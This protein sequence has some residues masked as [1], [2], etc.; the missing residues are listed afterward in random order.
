MRSVQVHD[1]EAEAARAGQRVGVNLR[2]VDRRR[3]RA[4]PAGW[5]R[6]R[7]AGAA[8]RVFDAWITLLPRRASAA[9]RR[10]GAPAPRHRRSSWRAWRRSAARELAPGAE[11]AG[12]SC[13]S[14]A[15]PLVEPHDR[16]ILRSL[17]PVA[18]VGGGGRAR[19]RAAALA[20]PRRARRDFSRAL[21]DGDAPRSQPCARGRRA[22][23]GLA[24]AT[25]LDR[26]RR[27]RAR[28]LRWPRAERPASSRRRRLAAEPPGS[29]RRVDRRRRRAALVRAGLLDAHAWRRWRRS[30][31]ARSPS[32]RSGRS[33]RRPSSRPRSRR[34]PA[35]GRWRARPA[36]SSTT[37]RVVRRRGRLTPPPAP[38]GRCRRRRRRWRR[39]LASGSPAAGWRR[40]RWPRW[41]RRLGASQA[42]ARRVCSTVLVRARRAGARREGPLVRRRRRRRSA[43]RAARRGARRAD[44][45]VTLAGFRDLAGTGRRN[46]QALLELFDREG[47][48]RRQGDVRVLRR[49]S[50]Y[51]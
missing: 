23:A 5:W 15:T 37:R 25:C 12:A 10:P 1:R 44:G 13:G 19:R 27:R 16:F 40:R 36:A 2:G 29:A 3:G 18:T 9:R 14:T 41:P 7:R 39:R 46:A 32:A 42:R 38:A 35:A 6:R 28:S 31:N 43:R 47:L 22:D 26:R 21:R 50:D 8:A 30:A 45:Q 33:C 34:L 11:A 51:G 24:V 20:R 48:T 49:R 17:S 4:R